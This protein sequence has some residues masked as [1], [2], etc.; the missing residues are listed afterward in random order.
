[1]KPT[2]RAGGWRGWWVAPTLRLLQLP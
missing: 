1:V 2:M